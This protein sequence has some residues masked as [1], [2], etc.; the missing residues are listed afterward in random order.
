MQKQILLV[1]DDP[2]SL[3]LLSQYLAEIGYSYLVVRDSQQAWQYLQQY[4]NNF[5][6]ILAD[7]I[8]PKLDGLGLLAQLKKNSLNIPLILLTGE[9]SKEERCDA[10]SQ[11]VYDFLYKPVSKELLLIILKKLK[12][13]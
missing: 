5:F 6:V 11:G 3:V 12:N 10:I 7:R 9:A 2:L 4:P 13:N 8:M 1:D